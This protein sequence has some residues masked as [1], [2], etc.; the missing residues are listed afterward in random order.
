M[1]N[2]IKAIKEVIDK[3]IEI[4]LP[5]RQTNHIDWITFLGLIEIDFQ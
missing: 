3:N 1:H 2:I 5:L 4:Y